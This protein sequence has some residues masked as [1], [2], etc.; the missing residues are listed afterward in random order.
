M[1]KE[2]IDNSKTQILQAVEE[3]A[4]YA[5]L[6]IQAAMTVRHSFS[7]AD[8]KPMFELAYQQADAKMKK[9]YEKIAALLDK[10]VSDLTRVDEEEDAPEEESKNN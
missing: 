3:L 8:D 1:T 10:F 4:N 5:G 6:R 7:S 2:N 9:S